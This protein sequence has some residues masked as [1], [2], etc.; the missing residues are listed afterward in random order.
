MLACGSASDGCAACMDLMAC[1]EAGHMIMHSLK[2]VPAGGSQ[3]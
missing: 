3:L 1:S 2:Q